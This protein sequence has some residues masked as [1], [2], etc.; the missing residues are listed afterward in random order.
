MAFRH[1]KDV[2]VSFEGSDLTSYFREATPSH[3]VE[4]AETTTYGADSK[5]FIVGHID[6]TVSL[7]G[8][9]DGASS[10]VDE[11]IQAQLGV[12][13]GGH[14]FV[15]QDLATTAN[16]GNRVQFAKGEVTNYEVSSPLTDVT[17]INLEI[18]ADGGLYGGVGL[19]AP[20]SSGFPG[21]DRQ[22]FGGTNTNSSV[23]NGASTASGW[24]AQLHVITNGLDGSTTFTIEDSANNSTWATLGTFSTVNSAT[25]TAEQ[26]TG[27]GTVDRYVRLSATTGGTSGNIYFAVGFHRL[28]ATS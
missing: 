18:Q 14:I 20:N 2:G 15:Q 17:S 1:G 9:F 27:T 26:I 11:I 4:V 5:S 28:P 10:A 19:H 22:S 13:D 21:Y 12:N 24:V 3:S 16:P 8:M 25:T 7:S 6:G 23:D